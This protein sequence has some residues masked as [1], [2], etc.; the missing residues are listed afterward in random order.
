MCDCDRYSKDLKPIKVDYKVKHEFVYLN[1]EGK[2]SVIL[3]GI[4]MA[5]VE[6]NYGFCKKIKDEYG[7][8]TG[9][10]FIFGEKEIDESANNI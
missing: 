3:E 8:K 5:N 6:Y 2:E 1:G 10:M 4:R 9:M 7:F